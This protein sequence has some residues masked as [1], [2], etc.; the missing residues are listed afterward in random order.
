MID[1]NLMLAKLKIVYTKFNCF[2]N[3]DVMAS[4]VFNLI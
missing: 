1:M 4:L 2:L 3:F